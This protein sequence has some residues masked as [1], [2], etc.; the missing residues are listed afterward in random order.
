M[1]WFMMP[2]ITSTTISRT[3]RCANEQSRCICSGSFSQASICC[4]NSFD[5]LHYSLQEVAHCGWQFFQFLAIIEFDGEQIDA[6]P[7]SETA[8][9]RCGTSITCLTS[10]AFSDQVTSLDLLNGVYLKPIP[11]N[12]VGTGEACIR[13][14]SMREADGI[15]GKVAVL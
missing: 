3:A 11:E 2:A 10:S 13:N 14:Y 6:I 15:R 9:P 4:V 7:T 5:L 1:K 12:A 8:L